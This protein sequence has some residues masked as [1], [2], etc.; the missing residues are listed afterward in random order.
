MNPAFYI[1]IGVLASILF[2]L[3][4]WLYSP[5]YQ[6]GTSSIDSGLM[7]D[8]VYYYLALL[9]W[10]LTP[11][12]VALAFARSDT[13][14][15]TRNSF[16][17]A[18]ISFFLFANMLL[19]SLEFIFWILN[20]PPYSDSLN[21]LYI[22]YFLATFFQHIFLLLIWLS[23][24][25]VHKTSN[26]FITAANIGSA[27]KVNFNEKIIATSELILKNV[28]DAKQKIA[29]DRQINMLLEEVRFL[30]NFTSQSEFSKAFDLLN[31][32]SD[33]QVANFG[34]FPEDSESAEKKISEFKDQTKALCKKLAL[35]RG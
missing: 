31:S 22:R 13:K 8:A 25:S 2:T 27:R 15:L 14:N 30:T 24:A 20:G 12:W 6:W 9:L 10:V 32:W 28:K 29:I 11:I 5:I 23:A 34:N 17:R 21:N 1:G 3:V 35:I 19:V 7:S 18:N 16:L 26:E 33:I 4:G